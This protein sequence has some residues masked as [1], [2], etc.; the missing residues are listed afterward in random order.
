MDSWTIRVC[1]D[2]N[3]IP[4]DLCRCIS[5]DA[6]GAIVEALCRSKDTRPIVIVRDP[7]QPAPVVAPPGQALVS[8]DDL[9]TILAPG[10]P[11]CMTT[12][13]YLDAW[14][15]AKDRLCAAIPPF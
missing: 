5:I 14:T 1:L 10:A 13:P 15:A 12:G 4:L 6:V 9:R 7:D 3:P 11:E 2:G 8:A